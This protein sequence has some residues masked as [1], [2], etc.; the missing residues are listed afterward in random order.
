MIS[1]EHRVLNYRNGA[2]TILTAQ[3]F[4]EILTKRSEDLLLH[5]LKIQSVQQ[6]Y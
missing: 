2:L 5:G 6:L 1:L 3:E 4:F